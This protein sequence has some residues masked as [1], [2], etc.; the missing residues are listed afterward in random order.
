LNFTNIIF[1]CVKGS[2]HFSLKILDGALF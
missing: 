1:G 2:D